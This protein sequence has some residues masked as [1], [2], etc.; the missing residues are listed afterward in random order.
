VNQNTLVLVRDTFWERRGSGASGAGRGER[1]GERR[2]ER[3]EEREG[4]KG[5]ERE[6]SITK[7][8]TR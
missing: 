5:G 2:E 7:S 3:R 1:S 8:G 4:E 6:E